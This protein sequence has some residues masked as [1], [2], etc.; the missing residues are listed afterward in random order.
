LLTRPLHQPIQHGRRAGVG[1]QRF[2]DLTPAAGV[3][4]GLFRRGPHFR[5]CRPAL[6]S[7]SCPWL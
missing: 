1:A 4:G 5:I 7:N 2:H 6:S 3:G